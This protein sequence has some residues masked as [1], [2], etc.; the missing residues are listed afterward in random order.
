MR[1][2]R[3]ALAAIGGLAAACRRGRPGGYTGRVIVA[4]AAESVLGVVDLARFA[5]ERSLP[6]PSPAT[7]LIAARGLVYALCPRAR[8]ISVID[9]ATLNPRARLRLPGEPATAL[10]K[11]GRLWV[12]LSSPPRLVSLDLDPLRLRPGISLTGRPLSLDVADTQPLACVALDGG[13]LLFVDLQNR[14]PLPPRLVDDRLGAVRFRSDG[15]LAIAAGLGRRQLILIDSATRG[16]VVQLP[17]AVV[18]ERLCF[19][20]DGGQLFITGEGSDSVVICY[21]YRTEIAQTSLSGRKPGEMAACAEPPLLLV[22][23]PQAGSVTAF[24]IAEQRVA[25]VVG[26]GTD[27]GP[28]IITPDEEFALV[29]NRGSHDMAVI[30]IPAIPVDTRRR[31][32]APLFTMIPVVPRPAAAVFVPAG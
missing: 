21:P 13:Q 28:I 12:L 26:V 30:R 17:L 2:R 10:M 16:V 5:F 19:S 9:A 8:T 3:Q 6:L 15:R 18:P 1:T 20:R 32:T 7:A 24:S 14:L 29:L 31:R 11:Q 22:S 23:N 27:P 25:A 4:S